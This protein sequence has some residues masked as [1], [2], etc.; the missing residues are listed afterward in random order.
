MYYVPTALVLTETPNT[1]IG[2]LNQQVRWSRGT[3]LE[4]FVHQVLYVRR[5]P[6]VALHV[7]PEQVYPVLAC[8]SII[9]YLIRG[10][11]TL[12]FSAVDGLISLF[13]EIV[14]AV[15]TSVEFPP[16]IENLLWSLPAQFF[17]NILKPAV[18]V[19]GLMTVFDD[20]WVNRDT[21]LAV[22]TLS[23]PLSAIE[24]GL[25]IRKGEI[26]EARAKRR[27]QVG[28]VIVWLAIVSGFWTRVLGDFG[29]DHFYRDLLPSALMAIATTG[30][31]APLLCW[32]FFRD[33]H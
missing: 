13:V 1:L 19:W 33:L 9:E 10:D 6:W 21:R 23:S 12:Q 15:A 3:H 5:S 28:F 17:Y 14:Y 22:A 2:W 16:P 24:Q 29:N 32:G 8:A 27:Y 11:M 7:L 30:T 4:R 20:G 25:Q 26:R 31:V 18:H